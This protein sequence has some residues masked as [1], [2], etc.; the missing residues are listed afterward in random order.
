[1][2]S[3]QHVR[4]SDDRQAH[5]DRH[6]AGGTTHSCAGSYGELYGGAIASY[7]SEIARSLPDGARVLDIATGA[8]AVP[9]LLLDATDGRPL[10]IEAIDL[11][12]VSP[13]WLDDLPADT[14]RRIGFHPRQPAESLPFPDR[15]FDLVTSQ[16]GLEYARRN[17]AL[18]EAL[19]VLRPGGRIALALHHQ[20]C[21]PVQ[22]ARVE[23]DHLDWLLGPEGL[24]QVTRR[25]IPLLA[26]ARSPSEREALAKDP[27]AEACREAFNACQDT[28]DERTRVQDGADV[29]FEA[30]D[31]M[32]AVLRTALETTDPQA[33]AAWEACCQSMEDAR[34]RLRDLVAHAL[35]DRSLADLLA[36]LAAHGVESL[37]VEPLQDQ[38]YLMAYAVTMRCRR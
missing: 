31:A 23:I 20:Q 35:D 1:M 27:H 14:R 7:W 15:S 16:Y 28:L 4:S 24:L 11:A 5:W 36:I 32:N 9:R 6:W 19:R 10:H 38:D 3:S 37:S 17:E 13:S 25:I 12:A 34:R 22:L 21:R 33:L 18:A 29:L 26:Q 8:G 30:R 2:K